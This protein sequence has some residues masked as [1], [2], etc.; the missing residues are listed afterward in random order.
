VT[1]HHRMGGSATKKYFHCGASIPLTEAA[2][3]ANLIPKD[4]A[5]SE[6]AR[7]GSAAHLL[8]E[9]CFETGCD[10]IDYLG[11]KIKIEGKSYEADAHMIEGVTIYVDACREQVKLVN[12]EY[13]AVEFNSELK[14]LFKGEDVGGPC[15]FTCYGSHILVM[16]DYKNGT[17]PV[18]IENNGQFLKYSLGMYEVLKRD[19]DI[20]TIR[21][22]VVQPNCNHVEGPVR[23]KEYTVNE[24]LRWKRR[25]LRPA[26]ERVAKATVLLKDLNYAIKV[27]ETGEQLPGGLGPNAKRDACHFCPVSGICAEYKHLNT[28]LLKTEFVDSAPV[29]LPKPN[30]LTL[31]E[32]ENIISAR[33]AITKWLEEVYTYR[34]H[35]LESGVKSTRFK[36]VES[37]GNRAFKN[38]RRA[39][40]KIGAI[41]GKENLYSKKLQTPATLEKAVYVEMKKD[42]PKFTQKK[43]KELV[44][45]YTFQPTRGNSMV[46]IKDAR[47]SSLLTAREDFAED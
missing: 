3:K 42:D 10:P 22:I 4:N 5:S 35:A 47:E 26:V 14:H 45:E 39:A 11:T 12:A 17:Y 41:I 25:K 8:G 28:Q 7:I 2:R 38:E 36:I 43:A 21:T 40:R 15:D 29:K 34:K 31:E 23:I 6:P 24:L 46:A 32:T 37:K 16:V 30:M 33:G 18:E 27:L 19:Y 9:R 20:K 1:L 44:N 13:Q